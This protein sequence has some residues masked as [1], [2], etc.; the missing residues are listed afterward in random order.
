MPTVP[1]Q[2]TS[3]EDLHRRWT[4][5]FLV[6]PSELA[7]PPG[8]TSASVRWMEQ[9]PAPQDLPQASGKHNNRI[10]EWL[11]LEGTLHLVPT[12]THGQGCQPLDEA[13]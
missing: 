7:F 6:G 3:M 13:A 10:I 1:M 9:D 12:P 2:Q 8:L 4:S 5:G 11:R